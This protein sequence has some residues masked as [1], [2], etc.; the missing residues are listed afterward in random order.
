MHVFRVIG[1]GR[2][3]VSRALFWKRELTEFCGKL[4]EFCEK[5]GEFA[6][7]HSQ[8]H[9][10]LRQPPIQPQIGALGPAIFVS[11][12]S[13]SDTEKEKVYTTTTTERKSLGELFWPQRKTFQAGGG[14]KNPMRT[15]K[16]ISNTEIF[17]LWSPF[18]QQRE[19]GH[20]V[21]AFFFPAVIFQK[22]FVL[23]SWVGSLGKGWIPQGVSIVVCCRNSSCNRSCDAIARNGRRPIALCLLF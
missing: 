15:R 9:R 19:S 1:N 18:F 23:V 10:L 7:A 17:P 2:N 4:G 14:Y 22:Y 21:Y 6:W 5:L 3:T 16:T 12:D 8:G 11:R 13:S 20:W